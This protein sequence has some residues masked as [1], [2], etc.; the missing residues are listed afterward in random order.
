MHRIKGVKIRTKDMPAAFM[1][2]SSL[3]SAKFP[4]AMM[5][6]TKTAKGRA[7]FTNLAEA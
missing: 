7:R 4:I 1:A 5:D 6:A 2:V 3:R